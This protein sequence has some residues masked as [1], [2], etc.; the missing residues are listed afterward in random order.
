MADTITD[1][2]T[3]VRARDWPTVHNIMDNEA[4]K[5]V[6]DK[7]GRSLIAIAVCDE[8]TSDTTIEEIVK[9]WKLDVNTLDSLECRPVHNIIMK[10]FKSFKKFMTR[11]FLLHKLGADFRSYGKYYKLRKSIKLP[12]ISP[13]EA[14]LWQVIKASAFKKRTWWP[15]TI[16]DTVQFIRLMKDCNSR[17]GRSVSLLLQGLLIPRATANDIGS[18]DIP[19]LTPDNY[20]DLIEELVKGLNLASATFH[21]EDNTGK[22]VEGN[23][24]EYVKNEFY[25][26]GDT[27]SE[28]QK[29]F[30]SRLAGIA[31]L[32][33]NKI[34]IFHHIRG[35]NWVVLEQFLAKDSSSLSSRNEAGQTPWEFALSLG[36]EFCSYVPMV[37]LKFLDPNDRDT[38]GDT[39][40]TRF[41]WEGIKRKHEWSVDLDELFED[42]E[43]FTIRPNLLIP[44][45]GG[46]TPLHLLACYF[47]DTEWRKVIDRYGLTQENFDILDNKGRT[48]LDFGREFRTNYPSTKG[49]EFLDTWGASSANESVNYYLDFGRA[50]L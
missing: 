2:L 24:A 25:S 38:G 14:G 43:G 50:V 30:L 47:G 19:S 36:D 16:Q 31:D 41:L 13:L 6:V 37:L 15:Y 26:T 40:L 20:M 45:R 32:N 17:I 1:F 27:W 49:L 3:A 29:S 42:I 34:D 35:G 11:L 7:Q 8:R 18:H 39:R 4:T 46:V 9:I 28:R 10:P 5:I 12:K 23:I 33:A 44:G 21:Y 48:P 22:D